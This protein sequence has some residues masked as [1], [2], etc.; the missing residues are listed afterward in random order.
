MKTISIQIIKLPNLINHIVTFSWNEEKLS[1]C[2]L[3]N[4]IKYIK[5]KFVGSFDF[6]P[7]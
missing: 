6:D 1:F 2:K 3:I 4:A 7:T 5:D